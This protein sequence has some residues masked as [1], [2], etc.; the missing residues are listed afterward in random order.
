ML[1]GA[2][3]LQGVP[4]PEVEPSPVQSFR[5]GG[6][7]V[8]HLLQA[9]R[10]GDVSL[11]GRA[12]SLSGPPSLF[13]G[14]DEATAGHDGQAIAALERAELACISSALGGFHLKTALNSR[15]VL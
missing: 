8:S 12:Q 14:A 13:S 1:E 5:R 3:L 7:E 2:P 4:A 10:G 11:P 9:S 15:P 6:C